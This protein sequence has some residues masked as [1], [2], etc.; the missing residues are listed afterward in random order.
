MGPYTD[1]CR[2][3]YEYVLPVRITVPVYR[4]CGAQ[5]HASPAT[6]HRC[7]WTRSRLLTRCTTIFSQRK[8]PAPSS[9]WNFEEYRYVPRRH[10]DNQYVRLTAEQPKP[11]G[12]G[13]QSCAGYLQTPMPPWRARPILTSTTRATTSSRIS[14]IPIMVR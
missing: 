12:T 7:V 10:A 1:L 6:V 9:Q 13:E 2:G 8:R 3:L 14:L 4:R 5:P 11:Y